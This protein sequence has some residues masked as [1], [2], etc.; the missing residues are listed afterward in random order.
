VYEKTRGLLNFKHVIQKLPDVHFYIATGERIRQSHFPAVREHLSPLENV[1]F[2][3]NIAGPRGVRRILSD[4]DLYALP[5]NLDCCPT[6]VL[7]ASLMEK[8]VLGSRI[9]GIPE[10]I[11]DGHT[12][13]A[14]DNN[15]I[16][17]WVDTIRLLTSDSKLVR[18][19]GRQGRE[20][21]TENFSWEIIAAQVEAILRRF[22]S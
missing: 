6:T 10:I 7:E 1:H 9:G 12:G 22:E 11:R 15:E 14:I 16:A 18:K 19:L 3:E 21:V 2:V 20:W 5:S 17:R 4:A 13:W 8:P